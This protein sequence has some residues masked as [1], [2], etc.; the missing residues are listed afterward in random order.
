MRLSYSR[1]AE[2]MPAHGDFVLRACPAG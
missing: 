1:M 2:D